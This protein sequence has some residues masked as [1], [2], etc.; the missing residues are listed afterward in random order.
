MSNATKLPTA[1][2]HLVFTASNLEQ[3]MDHIEELLGVRPIVGGQHPNFGTHN[4]LLSLGPQTYLEVIAPDPA[5]AIPDNGLLFEKYFNKSPQLAR[6]VLRVE[7][8]EQLS[9]KLRANGYDLG[10]VEQ[11]SRRTPE[12]TILSWK[13]TNP[14]IIPLDGSIPFLI[15]WGNTPHPAAGNP[16]GGKLV[17]FYI[18]HPNPDE[19]KNVL[20]ELNVDI[21]VHKSVTP[22]L[23]AEIETEA[24]VIKLY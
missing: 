7:S 19:V 3:G 9:D 11:G 14:Y 5:L 24:G 13:L 6:W 20:T 12:G 2:D 22:R 17:N 4:A 15:N 10:S 8:I 23:V 21:K 1:I 16:V 18:E